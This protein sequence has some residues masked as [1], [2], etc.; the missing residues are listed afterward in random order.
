MSGKNKGGAAARAPKAKAKAQRKTQSNGKRRAAKK[1]AEKERSS[2]LLRQCVAY[3]LKHDVTGKGGIK[4]IS[5]RD[6]KKFETVPKG[7]LSR[8]LKEARG[9]I[10]LLDLKPADL[11]GDS[12]DPAV[13]DSIVQ[14]EDDARAILT[15][16]EMTSL[17]DWC[18]DSAAL[19]APRDRNEIRQWIQRTVKNR[20]RMTRKKIGGKRN[21]MYR[22]GSGAPPAAAL[23]PA[24]SPSLASSV[25]Q[26]PATNMDTD[27]TAAAQDMVDVAIPDLDAVQE[28]ADP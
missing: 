13:L 11:V 4:E 20:W 23:P 7:S 14:P 18:L 15:A 28:T 12:A 2:S 9:R 19:N 24:A 17:I 26:A 3:C 10:K 8:H 22:S 27:S 6:W 16:A 5:A 21:D 1:S 25:A